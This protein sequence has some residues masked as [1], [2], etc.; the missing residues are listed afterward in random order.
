MEYFKWLNLII[1]ERMLVIHP[2]Q[3]AMDIHDT[4]YDSYNIENKTKWK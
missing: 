3:E 1:D 4:N 2:P